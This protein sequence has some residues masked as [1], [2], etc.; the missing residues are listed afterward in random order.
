MICYTTYT[1]VVTGQATELAKMESK[2]LQIRIYFLYKSNFMNFIICAILVSTP[3]LRIAC[4]L[5]FEKN[6]SRG[7]VLMIQ[8]TRNSPSCMYIYQNP[9]KSES[10]ASGHCV[11]LHGDLV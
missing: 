9:C 10:S 2:F 8:L 11:M 7:A 1:T 4:I 6:G 5:V 3:F